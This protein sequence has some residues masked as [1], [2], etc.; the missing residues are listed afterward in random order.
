[1]R[2]ILV[3]GKQHGYKERSSSDTVRDKVLTRNGYTVYRIKW[4]SINTDEG[5]LYIKVEIDKLLRALAHLVA[6]FIWDEEVPGA[7]PGCPTYM[8]PSSNG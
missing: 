5:K 4:K 8:A 6:R 7:H 3:K 1:M 2:L